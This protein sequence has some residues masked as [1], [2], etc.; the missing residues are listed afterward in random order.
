[1]INLFSTH[2]NKTPLHSTPLHS[3]PLHSTPRTSLTDDFKEWIRES[4]SGNT[5]LTRHFHKGNSQ[6]SH[7]EGVGKCST[8]E[9]DCGG[10]S[11]LIEK[12]KNKKS[13][14]GRIPA[15]YRF[16]EEDSLSSTSQFNGRCSTDKDSYESVSPLIN[17][18]NIT[19]TKNFLSL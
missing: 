18:K 4:A 5:P 13:I 15:E 8:E 2:E 7:P 6:V 1:M 11:T 9:V 14:S 12:L 17:I 16:F 3:T 10:I 19:N